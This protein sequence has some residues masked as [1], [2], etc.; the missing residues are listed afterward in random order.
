VTALLD[1]PLVWTVLLIVWLVSG[2]YVASIVYR[3]D[4]DE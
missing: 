3:M 2:A 1:I 4:D